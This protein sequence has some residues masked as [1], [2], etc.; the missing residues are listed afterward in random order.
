[1]KN[2]QAAGTSP[3]SGG[4]AGSSDE[5][6]PVGFAIV[7]QMLVAGIVALSVGR[8]AMQ[9]AQDGHAL[10]P[11][12]AIITAL[13][14]A[15]VSF[16]AWPARFR[17]ARITAN[18]LASAAALLSVTFL[19][20]GLTNTPV[21]WLD[22]ALSGGEVDP[23]SLPFGGR[24]SPV[25]MVLA[26]LI[27]VGVL[28]L[29]WHSRAAILTSSGGILLGASAS[30]WILIELAFPR[31]F[32]I[33]EFFQS[34]PSVVATSSIMLLALAASAATS[35][36][37]RTPLGPMLTTKTWPLAVVGLV[38]LLTATV[39]SQV[40]YRLALS[41]SGDQRTAG[42]VAFLIEGVALTALAIFTVWYAGVQQRRAA[43]LAQRWA[44]ST[45]FSNVIYGSAVAMAVLDRD[46][47][48]LDTN[49]ALDALTG[50][51][52]QS[53]RGT[54]W[55]EYL[56]E[57]QVTDRQ[58]EQDLPEWWGPLLAGAPARTERREYRLPDG[59]SIWTDIT[60]AIARNPVNAQD[61]LLL[62]QMVDVTAA[63]TAEQELSFRTTHDALTGLLTRD[64][65][66]R[67]LEQDI[68][69]PDSPTM[70]AAVIDLDK[71]KLINEA[72]G[73]LV[74]DEVLTEVGE[75]LLAVAGPC[76]HVGRLGGDEF[77]ITLPLRG[78]DTEQTGRVTVE[79]LTAAVERDLTV[80]GFVVRTAASIGVSTG[81]YPATADDLIRNASAA[82][83]QAKRDGGRRWL[84]FDHT[85]HTKAT[86]QMRL[87][88]EIRAAISSHPE[89]FET[90]F[91]PIVTLQTLATYGYESLVRWNH[92]DRGI[93]TAG[94]WIEV[95]ETDL[96]VIHQVGL[97]TARAAA[98]FAAELP[99]G[100]KVS[101]N[102]AGAHLASREFPEFVE[103]MLELNGSVP[104]RLILEL[105]ETT[106]ARLS[107]PGLTR[108]NQMADAGIGL[109]ADDFGT[110]FSSVAHLRDLPLTGLKLDK[111]FTAS[112]NDPSS[113]AY[114]IADGLSGLAAGL[115]IATVAEGIET[116]LQAQRV[117]AAGWTY[118]QGWVFSRPNP[119]QHFL[120]KGSMKLPKSRRAAGPG[121]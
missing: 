7:T 42:V 49:P 34:T 120:P 1:M 40:G 13:I 23:A 110:G 64:E 6:G 109:W 63:H 84:A 99:A 33:E 10:R 113:P 37:Y 118:G 117:A 89:Q 108:L 73:H 51:S 87:L 14:A 12:T 52:G 19:L 48:V 77:I 45:T 54:A 92:P 27:A 88:E 90:W 53:V 44:A 30:A 5:R 66:T 102:V 15:G 2:D 96:T 31:S 25:S 61:V 78:Q 60:V 55:D 98:R 71:F 46:G 9:I 21:R 16:R 121:S 32:R 100:Q 22:L 3:W 112:L 115:G 97:L 70:L 28:A 56:T 116:P 94:A 4:Q 57:E 80:S 62:E 39:L 24:P 59:S 69:T 81:G 8:L 11:W 75:Q 29:G 58:T 95:A 47:I 93:M 79:R 72:Y 107:G 104:G 114:Q 101:V 76:G 91:Q 68:S 82:L 18:I 50:R 74:G 36:P 119:A 106:L 65:T 43:D 35:R 111:S 105:T 20:E 26:A 86:Q 17:W 103:L 83:A 85:F 67:R 41:T 38:T